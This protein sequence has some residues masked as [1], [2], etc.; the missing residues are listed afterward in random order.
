MAFSSDALRGIGLVVL[1]PLSGVY[2][3]SRQARSI[4]IN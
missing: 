1:I 3:L 4:D 2:T